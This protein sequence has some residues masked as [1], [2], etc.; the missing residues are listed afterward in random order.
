MKL[1]EALII[2]SDIQKRLTALNHRIN[3]NIVIQEGSTPAEEPNTLI[4][5]Y[6]KLSAE[7]Q[8]YIKRINK[9]NNAVLIDENRTISD[10][11]VERDLIMMQRNLYVNAVNKG[12]DLTERY[13]TT[14]IRNIASVDVKSLQKEAD[15]LA[16]EY[17]ELDVKIQ[18]KNWTTDLI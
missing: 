10:A 15:K 4:P 14:E 18:A 6:I 12:S 1:A 17:R 11:I 3:N 7:L 2:R 16:K 9:T 5:E 8:S 13:S